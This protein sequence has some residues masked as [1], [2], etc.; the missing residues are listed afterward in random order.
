VFWRLWDLTEGMECGPFGGP[1]TRASPQ[2][3]PKSLIPAPAPKN[4]PATAVKHGEKDP[5]LGQY[6]QGLR[7]M[8]ET[9]KSGSQ[10]E[11]SGEL[12]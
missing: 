2:V 10:Q 12:P 9:Q 5:E 3:K 4:F 1:G 6:P 8:D 11:T 7:G